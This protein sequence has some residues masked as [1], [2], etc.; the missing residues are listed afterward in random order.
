MCD[1]SAFGA[2]DDV[3]FSLRLVKELGIATVPGSSF[4]SD[5]RSGS[6]QIRVA[7]PKRMET[8]HRA[9]ERLADLPSIFSAATTGVS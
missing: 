7:F 5:S 2:R 8:L 9:A 1:I 6:H 3:E 4:Y